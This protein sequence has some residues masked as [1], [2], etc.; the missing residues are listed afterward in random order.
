MIAATARALISLNV[1]S[2]TRNAFGGVVF[3]TVVT[4]VD[5]I[6]TAVP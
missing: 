2:L 1:A 5:G 4:V 6:I 3:V